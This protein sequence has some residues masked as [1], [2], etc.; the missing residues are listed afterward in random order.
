MG[1]KSGF[2]FSTII[3]FRTGFAFG[4]DLANTGKAILCRA[5][6]Q[7]G[8]GKIGGVLICAINNMPVL[9]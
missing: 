4:R 2:G 7:V 8:E 1:G 9:L 6:Y 5:Q 3:G